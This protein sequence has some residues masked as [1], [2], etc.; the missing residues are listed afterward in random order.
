MLQGPPESGRSSPANTVESH[1]TLLERVKASPGL[2]HSPRLRQ[3]FEYLC[4]KSS[5]DPGVPP[6]E[7]QIGVDVFG[8]RRGY[9]TGTDTIVRV[10]VS[11]LRKKL[12]HYFLSEGTA[13]PIVI[14]LPKRSYAPV[15]RPREGFLSRKETREPIEKPLRWKAVSLC[16][17]L[18]LAICGASVGWFALENSRLRDRLPA[19]PSRTAFR[20]HFWSQMFRSDR[21]TQVVASDGIAMILGDFLHRPLT[22]SEYIGSGYPAGFINSQIRDPAVRVVLNDIASNYLTNMSD[23]RVASQLSLI[24]AGAGGHLNIVFARDFRYQPQ[25]HDNLIIL[26]HRKANPWAALFEERMDFRYEFDAKGYQAAIVNLAPKPGEEARYP[27]EWGVQTY[28]LI[29]HLRKPVGEGTVLLLEGADIGAVEAGCD[30]LTDETRIKSLYDR[31]KIR[32]NGPVPD[33][34]ILLRAKLLR[35]SVRDYEMVAH[36]VLPR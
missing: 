35:G 5:G 10:Q 23:L 16:L 24:A 7:E 28:A 36:R 11:Q 29:A 8:R 3:L 30:L 19:K 1:R 27:V 2:S 20:D 17:G 12:E 14:D 32:P 33:F 22:L 4:E 9:D 18:L 13:E 21:Q 15:F 6:T 34:E 31:L 25:N 26:S